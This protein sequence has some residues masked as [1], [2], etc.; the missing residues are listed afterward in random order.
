MQIIYMLV[1]LLFLFILIFPKS[2][3]KRDTKKA[4]KII[5]ILLF[6]L[7]LIYVIGT[8]ILINV[9]EECFA[10]YYTSKKSL[11]YYAGAVYSRVTEEKEIDLLNELD[12]T[13]INTEQ[14]ITLHPVGFPYF[15]YWVPHIFFDRLYIPVETT[16]YI[17]VTS[18]DG[19][20]V[21]YELVQ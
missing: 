16:D 2:E 18:L 20:S 12:W 10:G 13:Y 5:A 8:I 3:K 9:K 15:E 17:V 21:Y 4:R 1:C 11:V 19:S 7:L 6:L 14:F